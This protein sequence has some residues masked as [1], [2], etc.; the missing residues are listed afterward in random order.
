MYDKNNI[1]PLKDSLNFNEMED[2]FKASK[3][4]SSDIQ[5]FYT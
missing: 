1:K 2:I 3:L 4:Q 5:K